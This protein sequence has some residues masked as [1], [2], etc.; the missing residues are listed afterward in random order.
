MAAPSLGLS[1]QSAQAGIPGIT[2]PRLVPGITIPLAPEV[3]STG[4]DAPGERRRHKELRAQARLREE[5]LILAE[6]K[7]VAFSLYS[8]KEIDELAVVNITSTN[9]HGPKTVRDPKMGP[10][11]DSQVCETCSQNLKDCPGHYGKIVL[12]RLMHPLC[13]KTI[14]MTLSCVCNSCSGILASRADLEAAGILRMRGE[15]RLQAAKDL[16]KTMRKSCN[17]YSGRQDV[18]ACGPNPTYLSIN[19]NKDRYR[20]YYSYTEKGP[21]FPLPPDVPPNS[22]PDAKSIYKI[23]NNISVTDAGLLGFAEESHPRNM[24]FERLLVP[25][26]CAR[27]DLTY[28]DRFQP[29]DLTFI[30][31]AIVSK[32][33]EYNEQINNEAA[34]DIALTNLYWVITHLMK[35]DGKYAQGGRRVL[36]DIKKRIQGK[37]G[38]VRQNIMGKRVN[39]AG[40]TVIGPG[41]NL[42][43]DQIGIPRLMAVKL[44][45]P[46]TVLDLNR[47]ELQAKYEAREIKYITMKSGSSAGVRRAITE[48]FEREFPY[49]RLQLGDVAERILQDGDVVLFN[50]QPTLHKQNIM[51]AH[52]TIHDDRI[53]KL[54]LSHTSPQNADFDGRHFVG[55][56]LRVV[57]V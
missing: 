30:Y 15:K 11:T 19:E 55:C 49:Y 10:Q 28:A 14:E 8:T 32:V 20:L 16:V 13:V 45:R 3:S 5:S 46:I 36:T 50:R 47:A 6:I 27:P 38:I 56:Y 7:E 26:Y 25:P 4:L 42:R 51:A 52:A 43:V 44:T 48:S 33:I 22:E 12:P 21:S 24:I 9:D 57:F 35:N 31:K 18:V 2:E 29:D 40:R 54:N 53:I 17:R 23:L 34:M 1:R 39:F 41:H 37:G